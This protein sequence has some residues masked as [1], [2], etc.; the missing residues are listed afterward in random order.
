MQ[1]TVQVQGR[2]EGGGKTLE[3]LGEFP[4]RF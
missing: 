1:E 2:T 3:P 4:R